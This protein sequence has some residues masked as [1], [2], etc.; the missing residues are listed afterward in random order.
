M[1]GAEAVPVIMMSKCC[2]DTAIGG[3]GA[4]TC[5]KPPVALHASNRGQHAAP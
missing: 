4:T 2:Q 5:L 3:G 1:I